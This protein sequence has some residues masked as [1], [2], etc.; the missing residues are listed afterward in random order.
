MNGFE[1]LNLL[2]DGQRVGEE[3][4]WCA[5][6]D[7]VG[8]RRRGNILLLLGRRRRLSADDDA[9]RSRHLGV[10]GVDRDRPVGR[11]HSHGFDFGLP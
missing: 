6:A 3:R 2:P 5:A 4:R 11:R 9:G 8:R 7:N 1:A 10:A